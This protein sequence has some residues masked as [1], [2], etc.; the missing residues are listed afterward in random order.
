M[1][2]ICLT[3][4]DSLESHYTIAKK[5]LKEN[6]LTGTFFVTCNNLWK[7]PLMAEYG[8]S[9]DNLN[10]YLLKEF[11]QDGFEIGNHT[12]S[13]PILTNLSE[14]HIIYDILKMNDILQNYGV[15]QISSFC[16]PAY[17]TN[18]IVAEVIKKL[19]FTHARTGYDYYDSDWSR[20]NL[21]EKPSVA[22]KKI[23]YPD[24]C[25]NKWLIR[26]KGIFNYL[27]RYEDFLDDFNNMSYN[28]TAVFVFHGLKEK[29]LKE[30]FKKVVSFISKEKSATSVNFRD[31]K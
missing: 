18:A 20:W 25:E 11:E 17:N 13:H 21:K 24:D 29:T 2:K 3:F 9:E 19:G 26:P 8:M 30:D 12:F 5:I 15:K 14:E 7:E 23:T 31:I 16:Y 10:F 1:K 4:D 22:R 6:K 27:Y 28:E